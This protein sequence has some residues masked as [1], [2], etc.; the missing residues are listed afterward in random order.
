MS[1]TNDLQYRLSMITMCS[2]D[3]NAG[4][5]VPTCIRTEIAS[6]RETLTQKLGTILEQ[7]TIFSDDMRAELLSQLSHVPYPLLWRE[8]HQELTI[9]RKRASL[10][11]S[12][13]IPLFVIPTEPDII[14][15]P[16][17]PQTTVMEQQAE[18]KNE[19]ETPAATEPREEKKEERPDLQNTEVKAKPVPHVDMLSF[20]QEEPLTP[21]I[22][23][24]PT[25]LTSLRPS[26]QKSVEEL[27][28][29]IVLDYGFP[30]P[31]IEI[32]IDDS[33]ENYRL[34]FKQ[35][36][37]G[38]GTLDPNLC[39]AIAPEGEEKATAKEPAYGKKGYWIPKGTEKKECTIIEPSL[40]LESHIHEIVVQNI[41]LFFDW[42]AFNKIIATLEEEHGALLKKI[43]PP[44]LSRKQLFEVYTT[45]LSEDIPLHKHDVILKTLYAFRSKSMGVQVLVE[46]IR[47]HLFDPMRLD[48]DYQYAT[49]SKSLEKL[50]R[51]GLVQSNQKHFFRIDEP[52]LEKMLET[53]SNVRTL[54]PH[55]LVLLV[56]P[57]LRAALQVQLHP[58]RIPNIRVLTT[59]NIVPPPERH[60]AIISLNEFQQQ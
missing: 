1:Q 27:S 15:L 40:I 9:L 37:I 2:L 18:K 29:N 59:E 50:L 45:L 6:I 3:Q 36:L 47:R 52:I 7:D 19:P 32:K 33:T 11:E 41:H 20:T 8:I 46:Q 58:Y 21:I 24:L 28:K 23:S 31:Q 57:P 4:D 12:L 26:L 43:I 44:I 34:Q 17:E 38:E 35:L 55:M 10:L 25:S 22:L 14:P 54:C 13:N 42:N 49:L 16:F 51:Q 48:P 39:F 56:P 30:L 60:F 5:L 53:I